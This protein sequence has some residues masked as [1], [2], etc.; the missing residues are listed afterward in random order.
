[1]KGLY[2]RTTEG[3]VPA[4]DDAMAEF[5]KCKLGQLVM[6][7]VKRH[8]YPGQHARYWVLCKLVAD[9]SERYPTKERVSYMLKIATGHC[10][11]IPMKDG[12]IA[13]IPHSINFASMD[14]GE[15]EA[16]FERVIQLVCSQ[17]L[18]GL[19]PGGL[20]NEIE[21]I[22]GIGAAA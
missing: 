14:Q 20:R 10:E 21:E 2:K 13:F 6:A 12:N 22:C 8:R 4:D 1:M 5:A 19:D 9:N 15:F 18:P 11:E 3:L 7:D 17:V 16:F